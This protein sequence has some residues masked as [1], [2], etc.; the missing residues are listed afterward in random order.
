MKT[1]H[2][3]KYLLVLPVF[4]LCMACQSHKTTKTLRLG[5]SLDTKHPVHKAMVILGEQI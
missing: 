3:L 4:V 2:H 1:L 5:H